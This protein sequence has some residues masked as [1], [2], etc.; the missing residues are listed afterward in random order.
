MAIPATTLGVAAGTFLAAAVEFVEAF[1]IVLGGD[2]AILGLFA[3][4]LVLSRIAVAA[5][6]R[7]HTLSENRRARSTGQQRMRSIITAG[8]IALLVALSAPAVGV[9]QGQPASKAV[10]DSAIL[11]RVAP[12]ETTRPDPPGSRLRQSKVTR[13]LGELEPVLEWQWGAIFAT[14]LAMTGAILLTLPVALAYRWTKPPH[15]YDPGVMHS[16][17]MLAPTTAGILIVI[18]GSL[19]LAFSLAGVATAVRFRNSLK[20]TDDA[21]YVL[22]AISIGLAAGGQ[23]LDIG[24]AISA[25][26]STM[27]VLLAKSPFRIIGK[28]HH[29]H[30]DRTE[31]APSGGDNPGLP[32]SPSTASMQ[33]GSPWVEYITIRASHPDLARPTVENFLDRATKRWR[34]VGAS[35]ETN[36]GVTLRYAVRRRKRTPLDKFLEEIRALAP[37]QGFTVEAMPASVPEPGAVQGGRS[38]PGAVALPRP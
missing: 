30:H 23:A 35:Q 5:I 2:W 9:A 7:R 11:D 21:V 16:S 26:F 34:L 3:A 22:V 14:V 1:T 6:L 36:G 24:L 4:W 13:Q 31:A 12:Q 15:E 28:T 37:S 10:S 29:H 33:H 32:Q 38:A 18:Q 19:A 8:Y 25:I 27:V 17:L 20:D